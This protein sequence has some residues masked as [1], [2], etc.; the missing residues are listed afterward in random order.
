MKLS[1]IETLTRNAFAPV[2]DHIQT[3]RIDP[4]AVP[5]SRVLIG[6]VVGIAIAVGGVIWVKRDRDAWWR[7]NI[8]ASSASVRA[9][10]A[11]GGEVATA[12]D[13]DIIKGLQDAEAQRE[14]AERDL[15]EALERKPEAGRDECRVPARCVTGSVR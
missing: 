6:V 3:V 11:K 5:L 14:R 7:A 9:A 10:I 4:P 13:A 15:R 1:D 8:A 2:V 12:T